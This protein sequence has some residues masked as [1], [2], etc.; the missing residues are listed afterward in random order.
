MAD[1]KLAASSARTRPRSFTPMPAPWPRSRTAAR[2]SPLTDALRPFRP[3]PPASPARW[4]AATQCAS[5]SRSALPADPADPRPGAAQPDEDGAFASD[6]CQIIASRTRACLCRSLAWCWRIGLARS[7]RVGLR[8][9]PRLG[10]V[11]PG[12]YSASAPTEVRMTHA[13]SPEA[14][15]CSPRRT[16]TRVAHRCPG[17]ACLTTSVHSC[18]CTGSV[19]AKASSLALRSHSVTVTWAISLVDGAVATAVGRGHVVGLGGDHV[20]EA[21]VPI[22][23]GG[24]TVGSWRNTR[25]A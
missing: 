15:D 6:Y 14:N 18:R 12:G 1:L 23:L 10:V 7:S 13:P 3:G 5:V 4:T 16:G 8:S 9:R 19:R 11:F 20:P 25:Q 22:R 21:W 2:F 17:C 24:L